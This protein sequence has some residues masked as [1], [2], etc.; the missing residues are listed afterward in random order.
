MQCFSQCNQMNVENLAMVFGPTL[1]KSD[2][3]DSNARHAI[4]DLIHHYKD[5][6]EV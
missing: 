6:F 5:I 4:V 3:Q 2:G 1:F